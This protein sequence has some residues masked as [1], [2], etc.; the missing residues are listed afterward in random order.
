M[1]ITLI[2]HDNQIY[3]LTKGQS[4]P[5][6]MTGHKTK[7]NPLGVVDQ[8]FNPVAVAVAMRAG[9]VA[10]TFSG[11]HEHA[12]QTIVQAMRHPGFA[13]VDM[14][15]P[16]ISFNKVNTFA[17]YKARC[18]EVSHD[19][20]DWATAMTVA[21]AFGE[22]I[23]IGV[24]FREERPSKDTMLPQCADGALYRKAVDMAAVKRCMLAYA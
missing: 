3:G 8:P 18:K 22:K 21:Q 5:T 16:C 14:H 1:N 11:F 9:F 2:V 15:S 13:L 17:W 19:P 23:P 24:L 6:T 4:S 20:K 12:V 10:R 7:N